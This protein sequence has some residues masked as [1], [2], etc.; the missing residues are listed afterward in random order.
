[1]LSDHLDELCL[2][3]LVDYEGKEFVYEL[4]GETVHYVFKDQDE[5]VSWDM[6]LTN[7]LK[8]DDE[9]VLARGAL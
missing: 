7:V 5:L 2:Q 3:K 9:S 6:K 1:M 4:E 8:H